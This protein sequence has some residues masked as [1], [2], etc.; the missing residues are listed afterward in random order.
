M[1][2]DNVRAAFDHRITAM[3]NRGR[4]EALTIQDFSNPAAAKT[5]GQV[6]A[7]IVHS[8]D[9][10]A[11]PFKEGVAIHKAWPN[12]KLAAYDTEGH[13]LIGKQVLDRIVGFLEE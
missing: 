13:R 8:S 12:S 4:K 2:N 7:L 1:L 9:D 11:C 6:A 5:L 3:V 10:A